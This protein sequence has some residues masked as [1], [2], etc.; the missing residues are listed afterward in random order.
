M[1]RLDWPE[2]SDQAWL[3]SGLRRG[4]T[5]YL[6]AMHDFVGSPRFWAPVAAALL[7][8]T[9][10]TQI[11]DLCS[12]SG[13]P[14]RRLRREFL[15]SHGLEV[16]I[17]LTDLFPDASDVARIN[18]ATDKGVRYFPAPIDAGHVPS[19]LTGAR[20]MICGFHHLPMKVADHVLADA[21]KTRRALMIFEV[22][23]R[24]LVS[25]LTALF[26]TPI[27]V[28]LLTPRIRP[29]HASTLLWTYL[30]PVLP[31]MIAWDHLASCMRTHTKGDL[32]RMAKDHAESGYVW[33]AGKI[34][35]RWL[36]LRWPY[37]VGRAVEL[38]PKTKQ[39]L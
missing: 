10:E 38:G 11:V 33:E 24:D 21:V 36:P 3:P 9:N 29:P 28:L 26:I 8:R 4:I 34:G 13:G 18:A 12:G 31:L 20:M 15:R 37:L 35:P 25:I 27:L 23:D 19:E 14:A 17:T 39:I 1:A 2:F 22:T 16:G 5:S 7:R 6:D 32:E 30:I